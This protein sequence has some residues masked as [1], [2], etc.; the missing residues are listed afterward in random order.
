MLQ[1]VRQQQIGADP[2]AVAVTA[3][4]GVRVECVEVGHQRFVRADSTACKPLGDGPEAVAGLD[5]IPRALFDRRQ[6]ASARRF[7]GWRA[8]D[9]RCLRLG[10]RQRRQVGLVQ[11]RVEQ[12]G[13]L[14]Q[15]LAA[16]QAE[17]D[18]E[19]QVRLVHR[20]GGAHA[21]PLAAAVERRHEAQLG[22]EVGPLDSG[23]GKHVARCQAHLDVIGTQSARVNQLDVSCERLGQRRM[24]TD[25]AQPDGAG[26]GRV[27]GGEQEQGPN[28]KTK[29]RHKH[30]G[31]QQGCGRRRRARQPGRAGA[32]GNSAGP[33]RA[34]QSSW[35]V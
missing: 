9:G 28:G 7:H 5:A 13:V 15:Q 4:E 25:L 16:R 22:E 21:D 27:A 24:Q 18:D 6:H 34:L 29:G 19:V 8:D 23:A 3:D 10:T 1:S 2:Q 11:W 31:C 17:L 20:C 12:Q 33:Q 26:Q 14:A 35:L 30:S 32:Y